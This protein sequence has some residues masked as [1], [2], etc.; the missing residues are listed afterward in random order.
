[1]N[2]S[3]GTRRSIVF[4]AL[5]LSA[6][7]GIGTL[8]A[9]DPLFSQFYNNPIYYNPAYIGL[10]PGFRAR[11]NYRDQ[12]TGI[13]QDFKTYNFSLDVAERALPGSGGLGL[14]VLSDKAGTGLIKTNNIGLG[15]SARVPLQENMVAQVGFMVSFVQKTINWDGLVFPDQLSARFGNIYP[16]AF[17]PSAKA[18]V[19]YP[20]FSVGGVYRFAET[21]TTIAGIQG[22]LGVAVHHV[23]QPNE[24]FLGL[25]APLPRK[26]VIQGDLVLDVE[27]GRSSSYRTYR[28]SGSFKFNPGFIYEKQADFSTYSIGL[29]I[30]KSS[31]YLGAW[32]RNQT[33][34]FFKANDAIFSV[35]INAPF[36]RDTRMKIMYSYDY[37]ITDLRTAARASHEISIVWEFDQFSMFGGSANGGFNPGYRG[38]RVREMECCPF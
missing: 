23:F 20:D 29:N 30:L 21:G 28:N 32:L 16:T 25:N 19:T 5:I 18:S 9:Q 33:F 31:V 22:T 6:I 35:G 17:E 36:S 34:D 10:T 14:L 1:M 11:F 4:V 12:W 15:T 26:L 2:N 8:R 38:G 24:S 13:P 7:A 37:L 3:T 27:G